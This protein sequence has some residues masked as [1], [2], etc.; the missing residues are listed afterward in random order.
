MHITLMMVSTV[1]GKITRGNEPDVTAWTSLEDKALFMTMKKEYTLLVM[2][3]S[4]YLANKERIKLSN[5]I[6]RVVLTRDPKKYAA[7]HMVDQLE[8]TN[9][10]PKELVENLSSRG[11]NEML[12]LGGAEINALF[13]KENL[14]DELHLTIEPHLFGRGKNLIATDDIA[15]QLQLTS[16]EKLNDSGTLHAIYQ[17]IKS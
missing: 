17:V 11:H 6:L 8:F 5:D 10:S 1:N 7:D 13:L 12:L 15:V 9:L 14:V 3:S 16:V 4:S 2:G